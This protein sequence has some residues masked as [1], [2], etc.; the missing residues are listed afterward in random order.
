M[1]PEHLRHALPS[2][3]CWSPQVPRRYPD[4]NRFL[5]KQ[6]TPERSVLPA[7][8]LS[9]GEMGSRGQVTCPRSL[10]PLAPKRSQEPS[11]QTHASQCPVFHFSALQPSGW[12][13]HSLTCLLGFSPSGCWRNPGDDG[14]PSAVKQEDMK[15]KTRMVPSS[16]GAVRITGRG[17]CVER[18]TLSN[19]L[20]PIHH[21][22]GASLQHLRMNRTESLIH[23]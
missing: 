20:F 3:S 13:A 21:F 4:G 6:S 1:F 19:A 11:L 14:R 7:A 22:I 9:R 17:C 16:R 23:I 18:S 15:Q 8:P 12:N 10:T 2:E 5:N